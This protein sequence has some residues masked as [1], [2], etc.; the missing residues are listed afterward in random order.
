MSSWVVAHLWL[1]PVVP[2]AASLAILSLSQSRRSAAAGL[3]IAGQIV[4]AAAAT[5][6]T[7]SGPATA[8]I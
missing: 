7:S 5:A 6:A 3:A 1:I 4:P 8:P 2:L